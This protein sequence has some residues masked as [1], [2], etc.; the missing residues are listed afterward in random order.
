MKTFIDETPQEAARRLAAS[1]IREGFKPQAL[2]TY[3]DTNGK[4]LHW[5]IRLKHPGTGDK[6]I[7]PMK[8]NGEGYTMGEPEYP[9]GK[10][11]Y[12]L[13]D[14][15]TRPDEPVIIVEGEW[16]ADALAKTG[17]LTTTSGAADSAGKADWQPLAGRTVVIWPDNDE[18][19]RRYAYAVENTLLALNCKVRIINVVDLNLPPKGDAVDWLGAN[20]SVT[21]ADVLALPVTTLTNPDQE[22]VGGL[23]G[24]ELIN[25]ADIVPEAIQWLWQNWLAKGKLHI[26]AGAP[27][28]GKTSLALALAALLTVGGRWPDGTQATPCNVLIWSGEDDPKDTLTPRLLACGA[29]MKRVYFVGDVGEDG[30]RRVFDPAKD[31]KALTLSARKADNVGLVVVDPVVSAVHGDSHKNA[32]VRRGLAPLVEL[33]AAL[34]CAVLGITHFSKGTAGRDPTERVTGSLAFG[35]VARVVMATAKLPDNQGG[36]R[37]LARSKSNI[38]PDGGGFKYGL[39]RVELFHVAGVFASVVRWGDALEGSARELLGQAEAISE[40]GEDTAK[41][42]AGAWLED[43]LRFGDVDGKRIKTLAKEAGIS[44]RTLYRAADALGVK[45]LPG[46]F[47]K[48]RI[49][50]LCAMSAKECHVC[51]QKSKA[52]MG[53]DGTHDEDEDKPIGKST[54][55]F[56]V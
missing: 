13:R 50:H 12:R 10:P 11:L 42:E 55:I 26:L 7:R 36:G 6:W 21:A 17:T 56:D 23:V 31:V 33:G 41:G 46:G 49:W 24:V 34:S 30:E 45:M 37:L 47:A 32:E 38:G 40:N 20:P 28:T 43:L 1:A 22:P 52:D 5:R 4:P 18:A 48:P 53:K 2:H 9:D 15:A 29:D 14:L 19:G 25:G 8:L 39:E 54:R 16:C 35:A 27:G 3:T 51:Q 44:E